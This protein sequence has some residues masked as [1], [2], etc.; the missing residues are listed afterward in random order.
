MKFTIHTID[1]ALG[2]PYE[3]LI[4]LYEDAFDRYHSNFTCPIR[5]VDYGIMK[6]KLAAEI[7][8]RPEYS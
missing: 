6:D 4:D 5:K 7:K 1:K 3:T 8:S 2:L